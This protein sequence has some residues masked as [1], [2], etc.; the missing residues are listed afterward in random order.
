MR[1]CT[2]GTGPDRDLYICNAIKCRPQ[3]P[4]AE[5][6]ELRSCRPWLDQQLALVNPAV[7][8]LTGATAVEAI[9]GIKG[10][11]TQLQGS[12]KPGGAGR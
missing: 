10:G 6:G 1:C 3:Q 7:I 12:G 11:M 9:L 4:T 5:K 2:S 8:V